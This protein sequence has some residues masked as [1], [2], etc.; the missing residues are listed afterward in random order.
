ML[1]PRGIYGWPILYYSG[2]NTMIDNGIHHSDNY[3]VAKILLSHSQKFTHHAS[4]YFYDLFAT[5]KK[6]AIVQ[7][8]EKTKI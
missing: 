1:S 2:L 4:H 3:T 7:A 5:N 6:E 8:L